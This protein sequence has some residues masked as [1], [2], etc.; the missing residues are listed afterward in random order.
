M[1]NEKKQSGPSNIARSQRRIKAR[2]QKQMQSIGLT[3]IGAIVI[4]V[5]LILATSGSS[6]LALAPERD[7]PMADGNTMGDPNAR[8]VME[9]FSDFQC[10][11]CRD[12]YTDKEEYIVENYIATGKVYFIYRSRGDSRGGDSGRAA[13]AAYCAGDQDSF[14]EMHDMIYSNFS[15]GDSGGYSNNKLSEMADAINLNVGTFKDCL[16]GNK[17]GDRVAEDLELARAK[18]VTSTPNFFINGQLIQGNAPIEDFIET[19]E[20]ELAKVGE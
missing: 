4:V 1:S 19:I 3:V 16:E 8:V 7:H 14:W 2:R 9:D 18:G 11:H 12:F 6:N 20:A 13:V 17:Y 15:T 5:A 10:S